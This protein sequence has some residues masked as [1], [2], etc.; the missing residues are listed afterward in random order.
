MV[1]GRN[2]KQE[3][4]EIGKDLRLRRNPKKNFNFSYCDSWSN[5]IKL[6]FLDDNFCQQKK[7]EKM[8]RGERNCQYQMSQLT[9]MPQSAS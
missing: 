4:K 5:P 1:L 6:F 9:H 3:F 2:P 7:R 8:K